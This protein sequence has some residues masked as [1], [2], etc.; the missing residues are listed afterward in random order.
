MTLEL[1]S[2][3]TKVGF[4]ENSGIEAIITAVCIKG[5]DGSFSVEYECAWWNDRIRNTA[6]V[7]PSEL[8]ASDASLLSIGFLS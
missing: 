4:V 5:V 7:K 8:T 6:W 3:G 1:I 2:P